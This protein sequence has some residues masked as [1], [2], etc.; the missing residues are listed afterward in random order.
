MSR[1]EPSK[2]MER[3]MFHSKWLV[4]RRRRSERSRACFA[5]KHARSEGASFPGASPS[6]F[7]YA[8]DL[9]LEL[10]SP[11][12]RKVPAQASVA[13]FAQIMSD[14]KGA[15]GLSCAYHGQVPFV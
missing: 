4:K 3:S 2:E 12:R 6:R 13:L 7:R 15:R 11:P 9:H 1:F 5:T 14:E 8:F 10:E